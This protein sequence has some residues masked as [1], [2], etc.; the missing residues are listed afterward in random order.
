LKVVLIFAQERTGAMLRAASAVSSG[1]LA[2]FVVVAGACGLG[3]C[4]NDGPSD[5]QGIIGVYGAGTPDQA[6][7][8]VQ[9]SLNG[10][11]VAGWE[12]SMAATFEYVPDPVSAAEF[13]N[14]FAS[15]DREVEA[16]FARALFA[17][18]VDIDADLIV[19]DSVCPTTAGGTVTW[20]NVE[21]SVVV[22]GRG[23]ASPITYR[24]F[25][26]LEFSLE[27]NFWYLMR[28]ADLRGAPAP[29]NE[30]I[31]CPTFGEL[32]AV[33]RDR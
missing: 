23:D 14:A 16:A 10:H 27:G 8:Y 13:P 7:Q 5:H 28:W 19:N 1:F 31:I 4:G 20:P 30:G 25:A 6:W 12:N 15:W 33:Y 3:G 17:A 2:L 26:D 18:D 24:G 9:Q 21:Y 32:R 22:S 29:W 11:V